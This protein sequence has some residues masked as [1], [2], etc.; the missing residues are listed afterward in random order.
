MDYQTL[1]QGDGH[2]EQHAKKTMQEIASALI[3]L[4]ESD[5][6]SLVLN[7]DEEDLSSWNRQCL[8]VC[9]GDTIK[10]W[11]E[12]TSGED[13]PGQYCFRCLAKINNT[14]VNVGFNATNWT[15][16]ETEAGVDELINQLSAIEMSTITIAR[17]V[18]QAMHN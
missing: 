17:T 12:L 6:S 14:P 8:M 2:A 9:N 7:Q 16:G 5:V 1:L 18:Q 4:C 11:I 10:V 13:H 15:T 3:S